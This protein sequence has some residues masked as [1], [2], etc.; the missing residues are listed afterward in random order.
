MQLNNNC[1]SFQAGCTTF[2]KYGYAPRQYLQRPDLGR[3]LHPASAEQLPA[4]G[5]YPADVAIIIADGLSARD[6]CP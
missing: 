3:R 2:K 6:K 4:F 1:K 5:E